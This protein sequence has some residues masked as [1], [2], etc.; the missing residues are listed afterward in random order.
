MMT[1][2]PHKA[3]AAPS[4]TPVEKCS[5]SALE[6]AE[7]IVERSPV[8]YKL[9]TGGSNKSLSLPLT[10]F[11]NNYKINKNKNKAPFFA[12]HGNKNKYL[13]YIT[14]SW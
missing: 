12:S 11:K 9:H 3:K 6:G 1:N 5:S 7:T 4:S 13:N 2:R 10:L 8:C 14:R